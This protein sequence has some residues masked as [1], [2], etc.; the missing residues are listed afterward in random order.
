M[1]TETLM[2][3]VRILDSDI[4]ALL[5]E[6]EL[7]L[8]LEEDWMRS[9][10]FAIEHTITRLKNLSDYFQGAIE[11]KINAAEISQGM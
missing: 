6:R 2:T 3:V 7:Y 9:Q 11:S 8:D 1:D 10:K 5:T 4:E